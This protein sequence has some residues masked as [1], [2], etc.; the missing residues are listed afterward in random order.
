MK[1]LKNKYLLKLHYSEFKIIYS[2]VP[3]SFFRHTPYIK[4]DVKKALVT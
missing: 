3:T 2:F 4:L 1:I